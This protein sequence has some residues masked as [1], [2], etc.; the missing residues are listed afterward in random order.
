MG[1]LGFWAFRLRS[2]VGGFDLAAN[3]FLGEFQRL[4]TSGAARDENSLDD[5][6]GGIIFLRLIF[7]LQCC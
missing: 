4:G 7:Y 5:L 1:N 2:L 3:S 6:L